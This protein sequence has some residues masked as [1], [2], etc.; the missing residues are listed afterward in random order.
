MGM[1]NFYTVKN[2]KQ[3]IFPMRHDETFYKEKVILKFNFSLCMVQNKSFC[4]LKM[5]GGK[6]KTAA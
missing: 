6:N 1:L 2:Y 3:M 4:K 5:N